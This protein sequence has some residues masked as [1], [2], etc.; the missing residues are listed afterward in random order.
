MHGAAVHDVPTRH[1]SRWASDVTHPP[2]HTLLVS[3]MSMQVVIPRLAKPK[4]IPSQEEFDKVRS[5]VDIT[6]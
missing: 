1:V 6:N 3:T 4:D 2:A 5:E